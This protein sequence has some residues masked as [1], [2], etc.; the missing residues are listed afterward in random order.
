MGRGG[1]FDS[2][3]IIRDV[4]Q[5]HLLQILALTAMEAPVSLSADDVR[6]EKVKVLQCIAPVGLNETFIGQYAAGDNNLGYKDDETVPSNSITPTFAAC[7]LNI[8]NERWDGVPFILKCG[9]AL[10]ETKTEIRIQFKDRPR[11]LFPNILSR[12]E[13]VIRVQPNESVYLKLMNKIPG[14]T[15][16]QH[17][18]ELNLSYNSRYEGVRI[19]EAYESLILDVIRGDQANFVRNDELDA[20]W[21]IF[22]PLLHRLENEK[23]VPHPYAFGAR[24]PDHFSEFLNKFGVIRDREDYVWQPADT[25]KANM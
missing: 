1:Y 21:K 17:I 20:A 23:I 9:K 2:S 4:M 25:C 13:L 11:N 7:V 22:T 10:N 3:G 12:N 15:Y 5:N 18:S 19:P 16:K 8:Q 6:N 14:L 24:A